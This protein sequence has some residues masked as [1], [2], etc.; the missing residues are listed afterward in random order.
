MKPPINVK[1]GDVSTAVNVKVN[2]TA[3]GISRT[4]TVQ[5]R[6]GPATGSRAGYHDQGTG[7]GGA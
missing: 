4:V 6:Y 1:A 7:I 2:V 5:K 3:G